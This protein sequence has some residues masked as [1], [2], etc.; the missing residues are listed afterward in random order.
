MAGDSIF[1]LDFDKEY[2]EK[3]SIDRFI[4]NIDGFNLFVNSYFLFKLKSLPTVGYK[5]VV[6]EAERPDTISYDSF[7]RQQQFWWI[8]MY[9]NG[10]SSREELKQGMVLKLF[11]VSDL[12]RLLNQ[13]SKKQLLR[14]KEA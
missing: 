12:E 9:Y 13:C 11:S 10:L 5:R 8:I 3:F 1:Y 7:N 14:E 2:L 4:E 6:M